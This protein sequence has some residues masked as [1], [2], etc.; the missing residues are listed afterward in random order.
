MA[1]LF[2][3]FDTTELPVSPSIT[4][5][6]PVN[7]LATD[8]SS[9]SENSEIYNFSNKNV[10]IS[11][12]LNINRERCTSGLS[13]VSTNSNQT[14][15]NNNNINSFIK[16]LLK[17]CVFKPEHLQ[18]KSKSSKCFSDVVKNFSDD[19]VIDINQDIINEIERGEYREPK[20]R[21]KCVEMTQVYY[22]QKVIYCPVCQLTTAKDL[23]RYVQ[24]V[25]QLNYGKVW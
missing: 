4:P 7:C 17:D 14:S 25:E 2:E 5:I 15:I 3:E 13:T 11:S 10:K 21:S 24:K 9:S 16:Y 23:L 19:E 8:T 18:Y 1:M 20:V 6:I 22:N 12:Q